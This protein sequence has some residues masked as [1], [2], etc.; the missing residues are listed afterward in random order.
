MT[1]VV[2]G[3][4]LTLGLDQPPRLV[5]V[6]E[7]QVDDMPGEWLPPLLDAL[8]AAGAV[9]AFATPVWMKKGRP[10]LWVTALSAPPP[11]SRPRPS[12]MEQRIRPR[13]PPGRRR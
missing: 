8:F 10:G 2:L 3:E 12:T 11:P 5:E 13:P 7:T 1:R 4:P 6:L 9:D